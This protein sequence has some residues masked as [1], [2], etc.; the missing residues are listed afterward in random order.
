MKKIFVAI[1]LFSSVGS[2]L[3]TKYAGEFTDLGASVRAAGMGGTFN[4]FDSDPQL[5]WYNP[6]GLVG[7]PEKLEFYYMHAAM[8]D[9]LYQLDVGAA[10]KKLGDSFFGVG[11]FR[12]GTDNIPFTNEDGYYDYGPDGV[13][14]T[15]DP[16]EGNGV[17]DPGER[18]DPD[19][20]TFWSEGDYLFTVAGSRFLTDELSVGISLKHLQSYIGEYSAFGFGADIGARYAIAENAVLAATLRDALGTHIRWSTG[21]WEQKLPSLWWG[22]KYDI[23]LPSIRGGLSLAGEF[24]T[25]FEDYDGIVELGQVSIDPHVGAELN[26]LKHIY[27]RAGLDR[28]NLAAGVGLEISFFRVDYAFVNNADLDVTH[29]I[30][31]NFNIPEVKFRR[32]KPPEPE[33]IGVL[34]PTSQ[35]RRDIFDDIDLIPAPIGEKLAD[36]KFEFGTAILDDEA[37][38][39]LDSVCAIWQEH[40]TNRIYI[41]GH[42]DNVMIDTPEFAD[43]YALSEARTVAVAKYLRESCG[44][45]ANR[46]ERE[47]FGSDR[48][49]SDNS[50]DKGRALNRRVE[51][52]L[53][54]P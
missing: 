41:E 9:N 18:I 23:D 53:W 36:V 21:L 30:G 12:N 54:E 19:A 26:L 10:S 34:K 43:N 17:W 27:L 13:P 52:Y 46:I 32:E 45:S 31:I 33:E 29:R 51:I 3:A 35:E 14:G 16:G 38:A 2:L 37:K 44:I 20:V 50:T 39:I 6:A 1:L 28:D 11:F 47:W 40:R 5:I 4:S 42:T 49:K 7:S 15:G 25:H 8:F 24:E 48:Q 22:G